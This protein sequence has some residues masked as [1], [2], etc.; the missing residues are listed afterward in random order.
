MGLYSGQGRLE[1]RPQP[2][3]SAQLCGSHGKGSLDQGAVNTRILGWRLLSPLCTGPASLHTKEQ[4]R[5]PFWPYCAS[6]T[7][8]NSQEDL[9][10]AMALL[11]TQGHGCVRKIQK[12]GFLG[13]DMGI[14]HWQYS[15]LGGI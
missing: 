6:S 2:M 15:G 13:S 1:P 8:E 9:S 4:P 11:F 14:S 5:S 7:P 3:S 10:L 12:P